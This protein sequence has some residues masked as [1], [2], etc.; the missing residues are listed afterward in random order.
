MAA[1]VKALAAGGAAPNLPN[2]AMKANL[3]YWRSILRDHARSDE[4]RRQKADES[5]GEAE[6]A[7]GEAATAEA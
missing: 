2:T 6:A 3:T 7:A 5:Q 1:Q 4:R